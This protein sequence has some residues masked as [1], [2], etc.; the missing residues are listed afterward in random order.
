MRIN[1]E[2]QLTNRPLRVAGHLTRRGFTLM[3]ILVVMAI[4]VVLAGLGSVAFMNELERSKEKTAAI[5][6]TTISTAAKSYKTN[7]GEWPGSLQE[8]VPSYLEKPE[9]LIDPWGQPFQ[10]QVVEDENNRTCYVWTT[11]KAGKPL[12][13]APK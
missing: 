7:T 3:E 8:L 4:I 11:T 1:L 2:N 5:N 10:F 13:N 9:T 6:S 12:G